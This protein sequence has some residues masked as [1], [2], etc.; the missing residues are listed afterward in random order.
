MYAG[1]TKTHTLQNKKGREGQNT[2]HGYPLADG[3]SETPLSSHLILSIVKIY[4]FLSKKDRQTDL[5]A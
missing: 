5:N 2:N 4:F 3:I 1:G